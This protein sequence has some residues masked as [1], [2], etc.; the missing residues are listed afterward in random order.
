M[1]CI[2]DGFLAKDNFSEF[3]EDTTT[4]QLQ[5]IRDNPAYIK[6]V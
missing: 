3:I 5:D 4:E 6:F 2:K 1:F